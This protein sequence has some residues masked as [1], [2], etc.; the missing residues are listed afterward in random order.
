MIKLRNADPLNRSIWTLKGGY[1][2]FKTKYLEDDSSLIE[3]TLGQTLITID[4]A[5]A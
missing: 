5:I 2:G 1:Q 4:A 3:K